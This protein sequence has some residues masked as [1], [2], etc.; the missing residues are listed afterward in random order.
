MSEKIIARLRD[1]IEL[2]QEQVRQLR[3]LL[4][5][6]ETK[7]PPE[8]KLT[9]AEERLY[10]HMM[11]RSIVTVDSMLV[12]IYG[13]SDDAPHGN[14]ISVFI[15]KIRKKLPPHGIEIVNYWGRGY[16]I[17]GRYTENADGVVA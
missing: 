5:D 10:R 2:L 1:E 8:Y 14:I 4:V 16:G 11:A 17:K 12:A 15:H 13:D 9:R 3:A 7:V 6:E